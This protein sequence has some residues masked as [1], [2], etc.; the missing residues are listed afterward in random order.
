MDLDALLA[1]LAAFWPRVEN[2]A[3]ELILPWRLYQ[4]GIALALFALAHLAAR[5]VDGAVRARLRGIEGIPKWRLRVAVIFIQRIRAILFTLLL[6][7]A[8][9]IMREATWPSRSYLL[10]LIASLAATWLFVAIASR[11]IRSTFLRAIASWGAWIL[12][13]LHLLGILP[14]TVEFLDGL[15]LSIGEQRIS[16]LLVLKAAAGLILAFNLAR[17]L[18]MA[19]SARIEASTELS[20]SI[21]VL[22]EKV[23]SL[24]LYGLAIVL[25]L[26]SVGFDLTTLTVLSGAIGLGI[27]FGL[28][29]VVSNLVSGVILLL[30]KSIKPGDVI[31]L[32]ETFGWITTL[33]ARYVSVV[34]RDGREYLIPNEDL[35]TG[36]VVNWSHSNDLVR[37]DIHFGAA[38][39]NDPHHVRKTA[40]EAAATVKRVVP[41]PA[42]VCHVTGFGDSSVDYILRFWIRDPTGGLTNV[43]GAVFLALW[44]AFKAEGIQIPFPQR[45]VRV[46][47]R[48]GADLPD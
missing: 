32:G 12:V 39:A 38:Y 20:P 26:Q 13:T 15:A 22:S 28:Q 48:D 34:T 43:R 31:S 4:I 47:N 9:A 10:A 41:I 45:E 25:C 3:A 2:Y 24:L 18:D 5:H 35:I 14:Q 16:A 29:K 42:P 30:D 6:W 36:Q 17:W 27:G 19:L 44:D 33:G 40:V 23:A 7:I 37:L 1:E 46:L 21:K 8:V 11:L